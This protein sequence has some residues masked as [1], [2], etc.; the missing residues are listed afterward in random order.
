MTTKLVIAGLLLI[1]GTLSASTALGLVVVEV[2][3]AGLVDS[4]SSGATLAA[5]D[6]VKQTILLLSVGVALTGGGLLFARPG[7]AK[8]PE[9]GMER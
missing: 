2:V 9:K 4:G 6:S 8:S 1:S 7:Q 5:L 3:L